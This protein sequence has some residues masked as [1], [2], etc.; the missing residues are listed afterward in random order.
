M[1]VYNVMY[2]L[3]IVIWSSCFI[4]QREEQE[5][6]S[7]EFIELFENGISYVEGRSQINVF[8]CAGQI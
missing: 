3:Y 5:D 2:H 1:A 6:E 7:E 4:F 8:K